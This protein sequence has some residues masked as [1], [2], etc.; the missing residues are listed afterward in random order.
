M[1]IRPELSTSRLASRRALL[2]QLDL[3]DPFATARLWA[4]RGQ[5]D[6]VE[7]GEESNQ[8]TAR[9]LKHLER[10][11][12]PAEVHFKPAVVALRPAVAVAE[13]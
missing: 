1:T 12:D 6:A 11:C 13:S 10:P 7:D 5:G 3:C 9:I 2:D 8:E 4:R